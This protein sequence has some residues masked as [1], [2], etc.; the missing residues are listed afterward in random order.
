MVLCAA[1]NAA[2]QVCDSSRVE[3]HASV[4]TTVLSGFGRTDAAVWVAPHIDYKASERL[5]LSAGFGCEGSLLTQGYELQG[6]TP[7]YVPRRQGTRAT[8]VWASA[9]YRVNDRLTVWGM[10]EH[11]GGYMQPLW[12][13]HS[14][15]LRATAFSGGFAYQTGGAGL[16]EMHFHVVH[17]HYGNAALGLLAHPYSG[18]FA[19]DRELYGGPWPF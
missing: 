10:V 4:G 11:L 18:P 19:P 8:A 17:D 1:G 12:M 2:A 3:V 14:V 13:D 7:S 6:Y 15:P 9:E 5:T 16:L